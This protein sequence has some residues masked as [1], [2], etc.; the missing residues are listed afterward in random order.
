MPNLAISCS[1]ESG[2][3]YHDP[4]YFPPPTSLTPLDNIKWPVKFRLDLEFWTGEAI[5]LCPK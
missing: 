4:N 5:F 1:V 2:A 3:I